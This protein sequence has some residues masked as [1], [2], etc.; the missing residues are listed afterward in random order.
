MSRG[1]VRIFVRL[2]EGF[3]FFVVKKI[4]VIVDFRFFRVS[5]L[6][7]RKSLFFR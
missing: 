4:R 1:G 2:V 7:R 5:V 6:V 3:T